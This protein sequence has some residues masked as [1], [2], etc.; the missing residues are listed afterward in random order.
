MPSR[1]VPV[2]DKFPAFRYRGSHDS[3]PS[4]LF[5]WLPGLEGL[6]RPTS[7]ND[8]HSKVIYDSL[9]LTTLSSMIHTVLWANCMIDAETQHA[10][11]RRQVKAQDRIRLSALLQ[12]GA[13]ALW[14]PVTNLTSRTDRRRLNGVGWAQTGWEDNFHC[15]M[16][17]RER[18]AYAVV[19][20]WSQRSCCCARHCCQEASSRHV[21]FWHVGFHV[22]SDW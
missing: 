6:L 12:S 14:G 11:T 9:V 10:I 17:Q 8:W 18:E 1:L 4:V 16:M 5:L 7:S 3:S 20:P 19:V 13:T 22:A 2:P 15:Q 21:L